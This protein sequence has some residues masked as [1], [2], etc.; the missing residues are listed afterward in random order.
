M[1][2]WFTYHFEYKTKAAQNIHSCII[3]EGDNNPVIYPPQTKVFPQLKKLDK[4]LPLY[5]ETWTKVHRDK[6]SQGHTLTCYHWTVNDI[7]QLNTSLSFK[8][9]PGYLYK[10]EDYATF[11]IHIYQTK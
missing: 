4:I 10:W 5:F 9:L 6:G 11:L 8:L 1:F 3:F 2:T 7:L